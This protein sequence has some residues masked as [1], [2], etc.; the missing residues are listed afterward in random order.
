MLRA[1][2]KI[3]GI[4]IL[5][6]AIVLIL[7]PKDADAAPPK[8]KDEANTYV[9]ELK[10]GSY[11]TFNAPKRVFQV[12]KN[13]G[14]GRPS[15]RQGWGMGFIISPHPTARGVDGMVYIEVLGAPELQVRGRSSLSD[16]VKTYVAGL[17][18][19]IATRQ[20]ELI[21]EPLKPQRVKFSV[22]KPVE[23]W[24]VAY[25]ARP[26]NATTTVAAG[27]CK[28]WVMD[29]DGVRVAITAEAMKQLYDPSSVIE[30]A[31]TW[32]KKPP[33]AV[34][35]VFKMIDST[36]YIYRFM[37]FEL[38]AAFTPIYDDEM[39]VLAAWK[40]MK[41]GKKV[42][43][44]RLTSTYS[45]KWTS[46]AQAAETLGR[47]MEKVNVGGAGFY[48]NRNRENRKTLTCALDG[49][50]MLWKWEIETV[51]TEELKALVADHV[52]P[53]AAAAAKVQWTAA[54]DVLEAENYGLLHAVLQSVFT[55]AVKN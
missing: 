35:T 22:G 43:I 20:M 40:V 9:V 30:K 50:G 24:L 31:F 8:Y 18:D 38:P 25:S 29:I 36:L 49:A 33:A 52:S 14:D 15:V 42:G 1:T 27:T 11:L 13:E 53:E 44:L 32:S 39:G 54:M 55:W 37:H 46:A 17:K 2:L 6:V 16:W 7:G 4:L 34:K 45:D 23:A 47:P 26:T 12:G 48:E 5:M 51:E 19:T 41:N 21:G 10:E 3:L 28:S